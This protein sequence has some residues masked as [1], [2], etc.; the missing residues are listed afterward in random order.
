MKKITLLL[1]MIISAYLVNAQTI[2]YSTS[3]VVNGHYYSSTGFVTVVSVPNYPLSESTFDAIVKAERNGFYTIDTVK[4]TVCYLDRKLKYDT[5]I[6][7]EYPTKVFGGKVKHVMYVKRK[8][9]DY[10]Y[11][12]IMDEPLSRKKQ[13]FFV[14]YDKK[15]ELYQLK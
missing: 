13:M 4:K 12:A 1:V 3:G 6:Y 8:G 14:Y 9:N 2:T 11:V 7:N 5:A 15:R 10:E